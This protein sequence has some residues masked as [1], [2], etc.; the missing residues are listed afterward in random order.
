MSSTCV[1]FRKK[2]YFKPIF[3]YVNPWKTA[4]QWFGKL[5]WVRWIR[6]SVVI[7]NLTD[8]SHGGES[9]SNPPGCGN[10]S[11]SQTLHL[12]SVWNCKIP[13]VLFILYH[14]YIYIFMYLCAYIYTYS[15][16]KCMYTFVLVIMYC[17]A[18]CWTTSKSCLCALAFGQ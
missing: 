16:Y 5:M 3:S 1:M 18:L 7:F 14:V 17:M 4:T 10:K 2:K 13:Q 8:P 6:G 15:I 12:F 11:G 9:P